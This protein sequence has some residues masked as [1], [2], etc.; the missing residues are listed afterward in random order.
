MGLFSGIGKVLGG[1]GKAVY[2]IEGTVPYNF[3][4]IEV[5][6]FRFLGMMED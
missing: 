1:V 6:N 3:R 2:M 4:M 5:N